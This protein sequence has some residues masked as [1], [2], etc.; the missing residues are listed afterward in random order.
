[1]GGGDMAGWYGA[2]DMR[3]QRWY[4]KLNCFSFYSTRLSK[5]SHSTTLPGWHCGA[6]V[7]SLFSKPASL[8]LAV[9]LSRLREQRGRRILAM[10]LLGCG[11][12]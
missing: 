2:A 3:R 6:T 9:K 4:L 7:F 12:P 8:S 5:H 1:M 10:N 11:T